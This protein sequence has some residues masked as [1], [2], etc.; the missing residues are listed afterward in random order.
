MIRRKAFAAL[1]LAL[2]L[3]PVSGHAQEGEDA[4]ASAGNSDDNRPASVHVGSSSL[5]AIHVDAQGRTLYA[6]DMRTLRSR[7][8]AGADYCKGPC[9]TTWTAVPAA[10]GAISTGR[11][12]VVKGATGPQWAWNGNPVFTFAKDTG[13][14]SIA[15]NGYDDMWAVIAYTPPPPKLVA[16]A[17][18][19]PVYAADGYVLANAEGRLLF[20][21]VGGTADSTQWMPL[22][23]GLASQSVGQWQVSRDADRPRWLFKGQPVYVAQGK[24]PADL[25]SGT[26]PLR[27]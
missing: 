1:A 24:S 25:P 10:Q 18:I 7:Y 13:A 12:T 2:A 9:A 5:G 22:T 14:G 16:P 26:A 21:Q 3:I 11:W 8:G 15:G 19:R 6:M 20:T 23:A 27:P 17:T 4:A